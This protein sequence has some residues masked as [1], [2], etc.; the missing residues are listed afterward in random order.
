MLMR[1]ASQSRH[2]AKPA[3]FDLHLH[4][5]VMI[6]PLFLTRRPDLLPSH[7]QFAPNPPGETSRSSKFHRRLTILRTLAHTNFLYMRMP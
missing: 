5:R 3:P 1:K 6:P 7:C 4:H 2:R